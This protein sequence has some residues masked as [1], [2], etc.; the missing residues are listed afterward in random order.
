ML[1]KYF[2]F[3]TWWFL[4]IV[5]LVEMVFNV[6]LK[7]NLFNENV[8][9]N[10]LAEQMTIEEINQI[11][12]SF[13]SNSVLILFISLFQPLIE[14]LLIAVAINIGTLLLHYPLDFKAILRVVTKSFLVFSLARIVFII[15]L[16]YMSIRHM[17]E[18]DF[19]PQ[20]SLADLIGTKSIPAWALYPLQLAN[21]FQVLFIFL[22]AVGLNVLLPRGWSRWLLTVIVTYGIG[23][24]ILVLLIGF[25][26]AL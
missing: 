8:L 17:D 24:F 14:I 4:I 6:V 12:T 5:L 16:S 26:T 2:S 7:T 10:S 19:I 3:P 18:L 21:V 9:F 1:K 25:L 15:T 20:W 23:L 22:L 13:Q 11:S